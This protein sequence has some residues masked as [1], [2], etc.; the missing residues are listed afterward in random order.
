MPAEKSLAPTPVGVIR[1]AP[2]KLKGQFI[3]ALV[4]RVVANF[5][6]V[7]AVFGVGLLAIIVSSLGS[8]S[9][10]LSQLNVPVLGAIRPSVGDL[11][12]LSLAVAAFFVGKSALAIWLNFWLAKV[13]VSMEK[14]SV[15]KSLNAY[16]VSLGARVGD[17]VSQFQNLL[18]SSFGSLF[19]GFMLAA[20]ALVAEGSLLITLLITF[21]VI[22]PAATIALALYLGLVVITLNLFVS[23]R[24]KSESRRKTESGI[25]L[26]ESTR[27][28]RAIERELYLSGGT[29]RWVNRIVATKETNSMSQTILNLLSGM[30]RYV[31]ESALILGIFGFLGAV[32][33]FS[34]LQS[35]ALTVGVFLTGGLRLVASVLPLQ[36]AAHAYVQNKELGSEAFQHVLVKSD[37]KEAAGRETNRELTLERNLELESPNI[38]LA[39]IVVAGGDGK[40]ILK[41]LSLDVNFGSKLAIVG[42]SGAGKTTLVETMLGFQS[43]TRGRVEIAGKS[44]L[45]LI[46]AI[47]GFVG[48]VP[49]A[50]RL[51]SATL[52]ENLVLGGVPTE[53]SDEQL[54][55]VLEKCGLAK[56]VRKL[57][58]GLDYFVQP[59]AN[60]FSGGEIQ[61]IGLARALI[62]EPKILFLD[63]ATSSLDAQSEEFIARTIDGLRGTCTVVVVAHRLST[64]VNADSIVYLKAGEILASGSF[65]RLRKTLPDFAL[66][67]KLMSTQ[68][69]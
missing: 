16:S 22:N 51:V 61:R 57:P 6:D 68:D 38:S 67:S 17:Q 48:Y 65:E 10:S 62:M 54:F 23:K 56:L 40:T 33:V 35:Q 50:P 3:V 44:P 26:L 47:P 14:D 34:D 5:L 19:N 4:L 9:G 41:D 52:R 36:S 30:P 1:V 29:S 63:E 20:V 46:A 69:Q 11:L 59:D 49:Q 13:V 28:F 18:I 24:I 8:S 39:N 37:A 32:V 45:L 58:K 43:P 42:P 27:G 15:S 21:I 64:V 25:E 53:T 55:D 66:A 31:I 7:A 60:Q 2:K 12:A